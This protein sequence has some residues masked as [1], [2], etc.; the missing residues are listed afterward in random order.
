MISIS[1]YPIIDNDSVYTNQMDI[2]KC[3]IIIENGN[4]GDIQ[5]R[6]FFSSTKINESNYA[7]GF[8]FDKESLKDSYVDGSNTIYVIFKSI[9]EDY[10][11]YLKSYNRLVPN[12][13][14]VY[15]NVSNGYGIFA[16]YSVSRDSII[17]YNND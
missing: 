15:T 17:M 3:D 16:G 4:L 10:Y 8:A 14:E 12:L 11:L 5:K 7:L 2:I 1:K 6:L 13:N 9:S